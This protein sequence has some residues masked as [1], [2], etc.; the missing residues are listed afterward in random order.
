[1]LGKLHRLPHLLM[2]MP[3][4]LS[5]T[6]APAHKLAGWYYLLAGDWE[7][8]ESLVRFSEYAKTFDRDPKQGRTTVKKLKEHDW[9]ELRNGRGYAVGTWIRPVYFAS[10]EIELRTIVESDPTAASLF[11]RLF[12]RQ[13]LHLGPPGRTIAFIG[14]PSAEYTDSTPGNAGQTGAPSAQYTDSTPGNVGQTGA[15]S[16]QYTDSTPDNAGQDAPAPVDE[17]RKTS[18]AKAKLRQQLA[19]L[20][21]EPDSTGEAEPETLAHGL[22]KDLLEDFQDKD[23]QDLQDPRSAEDEDP[24][25]L[26][27]RILRSELQLI[28]TL[29]YPDGIYCWIFFAVAA[30]KECVPIDW[31][32]APGYTFC[33]SDWVKLQGIIERA[34]KQPEDPAPRDR[35]KKSAK[36]YFL[37]SLKRLITEGITEDDQHAAR[38]ADNDDFWKC[39]NK[40]K[41]TAKRIGYPWRDCEMFQS[42]N[43]QKP[44][45][46]FN[47]LRTKRTV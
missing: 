35:A 28:R 2:P 46:R 26:V 1:M 14:A 19:P 23:N 17:L 18:E 41:A 3:L 32:Y 36:K 4:L 5:Q 47:R 10:Q 34:N 27:N 44:A 40:A 21:C 39:Y 11:L 42:Y 12:S 24:E 43:P 33:E 25:N 16:A 38:I 29:K 9:W 13:D 15:P 22:R 30:M 20:L 45:I 7:R 8:M 31:P 37:G 6:L